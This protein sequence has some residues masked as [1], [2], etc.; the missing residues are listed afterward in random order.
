MR[1]VAAREFNI[2]PNAASITLEYDADRMMLLDQ[3]SSRS[4]K[5]ALNTPLIALISSKGE[6]S[7]GNGMSFTLEVPTDA[8]EIRVSPD[9]GAGRQKNVITWQGPIFGKWDVEFIREKSLNQEVSDFFVQSIDDL[10]HNYIWVLLALF[11]V[12]VVFKFLHPQE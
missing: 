4:T 1:I 12:V 2:H 9:P 11:G 6:I 10:R 3:F 5:Y 8:Q 7:L